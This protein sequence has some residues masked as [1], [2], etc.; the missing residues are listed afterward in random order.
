MKNFES[1]GNPFV[2]TGR[3]VMLYL[4]KYSGLNGDDLSDDDIKYIHEKYFHDIARFY[5]NL[6]SFT[7]FFTTNSLLYQPSYAGK[8]VEYYYK[9][10]DNICSAIGKENIKRPC[11]VC[12]NPL[13]LDIDLM[14]KPVVGKSTSKEKRVIGRE[15]FPLSGSLRNDAQALPDATEPP[16][17]CATCLLLANYSPLASILYKRRL[18][19]LTSDNQQLIRGSITGI[20]KDNYNK[21][22][23]SKSALKG[24]KNP[25]E[26]F[27]IML[28]LDIK[29]RET[30]GGTVGLWLFTNSGQDPSISFEIIPNNVL[31]FINELKS[32]VGTEEVNR[33]LD[34]PHFDLLDHI[35]NKK[36]AWGLYPNPKKG[37]EGASGDFYFLY[38]NICLGRYPE[39]ITLAQK[40][41]VE[42]KQYGDGA[43]VITNGRIKKAMLTLVNTGKTTSPEYIPFL[44]LD[45][46]ARHKMIKFYLTTGASIPSWN[47]IK[48]SVKEDELLWLASSIFRYR[49]KDR[50]RAWLQDKVKSAEFE[51]PL[52][53]YR[54][55]SK[56][57]FSSA[58]SYLTVKKAI[59]DEHD[60]LIPDRLFLIRL[61]FME[62][63]RSDIQLNA[64]DTAVL[65]GPNSSGL[66]NKIEELILKNAEK[67][68]LARGGKRY[69]EELE[70]I[71]NNLYKLI[72]KSWVFN[73]TEHE[74]V[75][76]IIYDDDG[77]V[78]IKGLFKIALLL[79][80]HYNSKKEGPI[81]HS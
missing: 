36:D 41:A 70:E 69:G 34:I 72:K 22:Q 18:A 2:D 9:T 33:I 11:E 42:L 57:A 80:N 48:S 59:M 71:S 65:I 29:V 10:M 60:A 1:T 68:E 45:Q 54:N 81:S 50:G 37:R 28:D 17:I 76:E 49:I 8:Q 25:N 77:R 53:I 73:G 23:L 35:I 26:L 7:M 43:N 19:L 56:T 52:F 78:S 32:K 63:L 6:P 79:V 38:Q 62:W 75:N 13:S 66:S 24:K 30:E 67:R 5:K 4:K 44:K 21:I 61:L 40:I 46:A 14:V 39:A 16:H 27:K 15:W 51:R 12:G 31:S 64:S 3:I 20:I 55:I 47:I 74:L 58:I